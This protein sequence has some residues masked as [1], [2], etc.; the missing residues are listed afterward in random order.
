MAQAVFPPLPLADWRPTRDTIQTYAQVLGKVR[1][2]MAPKQKH[3]GHVSLQVTAVGLTTGPMAAGDQVVEMVLDCTA[4]T[5]TISTSKGE[6]LQMDL[7]GQSTK[8]FC[9]TAL[10]ALEAIGVRPDID[11][12]KFASETP[13]TYDKQ[14]VE[15]FWQALTQV[16]GVFKQFKGE[17]REETGPVQLW[18]HHFD[19]AMLWFSG[20]L[21]PG[22]DAADEEKADEQMNFGFSTG[23]EG[24]ADPYFYATA[25]PWPAGMMEGTLPAGASW[26]EQGWRGG[27]LRYEVLLEQDNPKEYLLSFLQAVQAAGSGRMRG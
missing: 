11:Q 23:D 7:R 20:R 18:P 6:R 25:Y 10:A 1:G 26:N 15:T 22:E 2:A 9:E 27:L 3:W 16:D 8:E 5:L 21:V 24:I 14:A 13:G 4:H 12:S 19:L 17:L